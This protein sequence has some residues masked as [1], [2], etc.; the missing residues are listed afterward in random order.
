MR[1]P[2][3]PA[4]HKNARVIRSS[5]ALHPCIFPTPALD[6]GFLFLFFFLWGNMSFLSI[7]GQIVQRFNQD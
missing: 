1:A 5:A 7:P 6:R 3:S 2:H 4:L